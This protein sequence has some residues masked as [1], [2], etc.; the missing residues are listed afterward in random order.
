[1]LCLMLPQRDAIG[2][3]DRP[4]VSLCSTRKTITWKGLAALISWD[5]DMVSKRND[6]MANLDIR[7]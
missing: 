3:I 1:M 4:I 6:T 5:V 2:T 7:V